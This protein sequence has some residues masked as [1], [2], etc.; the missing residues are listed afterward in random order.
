MGCLHR[1]WRGSLPRTSLK[2]R[3]GHSVVQRSATSSKLR[4]GSSALGPQDWGLRFLADCQLGLLSAPTGLSL[5]PCLVVPPVI[6]T[7]N[8]ESPYHQPFHALISLSLG[9][10]QSLLRT[11]AS[12]VAQLVK[13]LPAVWETWVQSLGWEDALEKGKATHSSILAWR[14]GSPWTMVHGVSKSWTWLSDFHF[15]LKLKDTWLLRRKAMINL[16]NILESRYITL[17]TKIHLVKAMVFPVV[18]YECE[19]WNVKKAEHR[20]IDDFELWCWLEKT[21]E[22][23]LDCKEIQS[24]HPKGNQSWIFIGRTDVE[25]EISILWPHDPTSPTQWTRVWASSGSWWWTGKP[26]VLQSMGLQRV[27]QD[28]PTDWLNGTELTEWTWD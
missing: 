15:T 18:L 6:K 14:M 21:L 17:P 24:V 25:A 13:N 2:S 11:K 12:L 8:R 3:S 23:P 27:G 5:F 28:R 22:S 20:R 26:R 7:S 10:S 9:R 19:S 4:A 16:D 1:A